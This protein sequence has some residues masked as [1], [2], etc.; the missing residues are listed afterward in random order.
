[1]TDVTVGQVCRELAE[2]VSGDHDSV[3]TSA[4]TFEVEVRH[5]FD[6]DLQTSTSLHAKRV[7]GGDGWTFEI[8]WT[9]PLGGA[10]GPT[11]M[12]DS[13]VPGGISFDDLLI[14]LNA[15]DWTARPAKI[16]AGGRTWRCN[17]ERIGE[18]EVVLTGA[19]FMGDDTS[20]ALCYE[21][22]A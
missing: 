6:A 11:L 19:L 5:Q 9:A 12:S 20:L 10:S 18:T 21:R 8:S 22:G 7:I 3:T 1:M 15:A 4:G 14:E 2:M 13:G 17:H 16:S